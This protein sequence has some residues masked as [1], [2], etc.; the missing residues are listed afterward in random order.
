[1]SAF[2]VPIYVCRC[3]SISAS[4]PRL[5]LSL[6]VSLS[7]P[8]SLS[9]YLIDSVLPPSAETAPA[10]FEGESR[11]PSTSDSEHRSWPLRTLPINHPRV[12]P[13][14]RFKVC[15]SLAFISDRKP[16]RMTQ[17]FTDQH[18]IRLHR[19]VGHICRTLHLSHP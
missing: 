9:M 11:R 16:N 10:S 1:M 19:S 7:L 4:L 13:D 6:P 14:D 12:G 15:V 18:L 5:S 3:L 2:S 8:L 17:I